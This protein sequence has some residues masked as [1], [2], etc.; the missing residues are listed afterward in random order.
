[1]GPPTVDGEVASATIVDGRGA[2]RSGRFV[3]ALR[4]D[5]LAVGPR[6]G[7]ARRWCYSA[8]GRGDTVVGAA[9]AQLGPLVVAFAFA[10]IDGVTATWDARGPATG[11]NGVGPVPTA[12]AHASHRGARVQLDGRGGLVLDVPTEQGRLVARIVTS[13][14]VTPVVLS[15]PTPAGGW[16][17]TEKAAGTRAELVMALG[18]R[19]ARIHDDAGG[20]R[21]WTAGRQD[22]RTTWRWAAGAGLAADGRR[23][24]LNSST[25]MNGEGPG[26][27]IV[28]IDGA[29]HRVEVTALHPLDEASP[30]AGWVLRGPGAQLDLSPAGA[31][32]KREHVG[33][34]VSEYQQPIGRWRGRLPLGGAEPTE[35][36]LSGVAEDHLAVW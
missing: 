20:W 15:T 35:V 25:G 34:I 21:D 7:R 2:L 36:S 1:M 9:I 24:G 31:R 30:E 13:E 6:R 17:V 10:T 27:D 8:A 4:Q 16:N 18:E 29:P 28:W 26:E 23:V 14:D 3:G 12:G 33:P 22:R 11:S 32:V 19:P 5:P